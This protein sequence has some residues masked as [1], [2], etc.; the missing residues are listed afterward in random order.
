M[1]VG[2]TAASTTQAA[3]AD[4]D[5]PASQGGEAG[6]TEPQSEPPR[7]QAPDRA[8]ALPPGR[9]PAVGL[10]V[11]ATRRERDNPSPLSGLPPSTPANR[12]VLQ[13]ARDQAR[14]A[15]LPSAGDAHAALRNLGEDV[16]QRMLEGHHQ[17]GPQQVQA[18][19]AR[20]ST[21]EQISNAQAAD[22]M[23]LAAASS[24]PAMLDG[25]LGL[26]ASPSAA[27]PPDRPATPVTSPPPPRPTARDLPALPP[28]RPALG[29][30]PS[31]DP[32]TR[33]PDVRE[34]DAAWREAGPGVNP[35]QD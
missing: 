17:G 16:R 30:Q 18:E 15:P 25:L 21:S 6:V 26:P 3:V 31:G 19:M 24:S 7:A 28:P 13:R 23:T 10:A 32:R 9:E 12:A 33:S 20:Y 35:R 1:A 5:G 14:A 11:G 4:T 29:D 8:E 22:F 34:R 27:K 2:S